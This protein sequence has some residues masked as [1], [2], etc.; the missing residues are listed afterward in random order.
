MP[1]MPCCCGCCEC[2][3]EI[4]DELLTSYLID[5]SGSWDFSG[6]E[7][8][9]CDNPCAES[10]EV[11]FT[12]EQSGGCEFFRDGMGPGDVCIGGYPVNV[13][14]LSLECEGWVVYIRFFD[15]AGYCEAVVAGPELT[16]R[17]SGSACTSDP[18]GTY[19]LIAAVGCIGGPNIYP[20]TIT[21][22]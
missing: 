4:I 22:S 10:I 12:A 14:N 17:K 6:C 15:P 20:A 9:E 16:Y 21:V 1:V 13:I 2:T 3:Q 5:F 7:T 18:T 19:E 11:L 8:S